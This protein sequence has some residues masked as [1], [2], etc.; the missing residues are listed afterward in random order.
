MRPLA[1]C[2]AN[3]TI[4][5]FSTVIVSVK[6]VGL[7]LDKWVR[8]SGERTRH[9]TDGKQTSPRKRLQ[10]K[11]LHGANSTALFSYYL[12]FIFVF[13]QL[14]SSPAKLFIFHQW[15]TLLTQQLCQKVTFNNQY[16]PKV[17]KYLRSGHILIALVVSFWQ[18]HLCRNSSYQVEFMLII[19]SMYFVMKNTI[20]QVDPDSP[21]L[22]QVKV[23]AHCPLCPCMQRLLNTCRVYM[24]LTAGCKKV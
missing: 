22:L 20:S 5:A 12:T 17:D 8:I 2:Q 24:C 13:L 23:M 3:W 14:S 9:Q 7:Y 19:I 1:L 18:L 15:N 21:H 6:C 11:L 10:T 4:L 16:S